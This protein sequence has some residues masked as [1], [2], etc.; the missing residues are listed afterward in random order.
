MPQPGDPLTKHRP[1]RDELHQ[2][3]NACVGFPTG[4]SVVGCGI[5]PLRISVLHQITFQQIAS[6]QEFSQYVVFRRRRVQ[7]SDM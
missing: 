6:P 4:V 1:R 5:I 7:A 2:A 3:K